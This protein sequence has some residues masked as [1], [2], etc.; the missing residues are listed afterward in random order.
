M[1]TVNSAAS[2][3]RSFA[4]SS[5]RPDRRHF[6]IGV[7]GARDGVEEGP[8]VRVAQRDPDRGLAGVVTEMRV[9]LRPPDVAGDVDV[10]RN[11]QAVVRLQPSVLRRHADRVQA[12]AVEREVAAD[13]EQDLVALDRL[14][15]VVELDDVGAAFTLAGSHARRARPEL[16][17]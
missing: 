3:P 1:S 17:A 6:R 13:R 7:R 2:M 10:L 9:H 12:E 16:A 8:I 15:A 14:G 5:R 4:C 11:P